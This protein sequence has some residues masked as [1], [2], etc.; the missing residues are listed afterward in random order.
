LAWGDND[1]HSKDEV[2]YALVGSPEKEIPSATNL[3]CSKVHLEVD[4]YLYSTIVEQ[5][6]ELIVSPK[7]ENSTAATLRSKSG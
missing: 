6:I 7:I 2:F 3:P 5:L 4:S 1:G